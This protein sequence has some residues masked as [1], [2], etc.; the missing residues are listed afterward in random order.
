[1][2]ELSNGT[3]IEIG[4]EIVRTTLPGGAVVTAIPRGDAEQ[5]RTAQELGYGAEVAAMTRDHDPLHSVLADWLGMPCSE[6]LLVAAGD[7]STDPMLA[8]LEERAVIALQ[9]LMVAVGATPAGLAAR[10]RR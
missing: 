1:M 7:N 6:A 3:T 10:L 9:A 2:L 8:E 4:A 5:A